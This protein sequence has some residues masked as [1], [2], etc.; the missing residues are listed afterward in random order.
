MPELVEKAK[1]FRA[2]LDAA[3]KH[4]APV[5]FEWYPYNSLSSV[6]HLKILL[7]DAHERVLET[8]RDKGILDLGCGDGDLAFFLESLGYGVTGIDYSASNQNC[9]RGL[10]TLH[11]ELGST[12]AIR[13]VDAD[14]EFPLDVQYGLTLCMGLLYH[15]K[16]P[17]FVLERLA[18]VSDYCVLSTR[19]ARRLPGGAPMPANQALAYLLGEEELNQ[20]DTNFW[21]FSEPGLRRVLERTRWEILEFFTTGDTD[22]SDPVS[23]DHDERA[24]CLLRSHYGCQHLDLEEGWHAIEQQG[25]RWT[26]RRFTAR[27]ASRSNVKYTKVTL[28]FF[29]PPVLIE[30]LGSITLGARIDGI[31]LAPLVVR[32]QGIHTFARGIPAP[33]GIVSVIFHLD[34][35]IAPTAEDSRE[36]GVIVAALDF[37]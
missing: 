31:E 6:H 29:V 18:R 22:A 28:R 14:S 34:K 33:S 27:A 2:I 3:R 8:A 15:L 21:I 26:A 19:I 30:R 20:D 10:Q 4:A 1:Q 37:T 24:F 5:D 17:V 9:M 25:W 12:I 23:L 36:L 16:N 13:E 35:V 11:A 32:A 7:G